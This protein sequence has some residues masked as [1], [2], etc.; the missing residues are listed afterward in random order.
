[1]SLRLL[2]LT[3]RAI[4]YIIVSAFIILKW[5]DYLADIGRIVIHSDVYVLVPYFLFSA[6]LFFSA[7]TVLPELRRLE[8]INRSNKM[9]RDKVNTKDQNEIS[10][11][12]HYNAFIRYGSVAFALYWIS[13]PFWTD[14]YGNW[15]HTA[16]YPFA[17]ITGSIIMVYALRT[18]WYAVSIGEGKIIVKGFCTREY[19]LENVFSVKLLRT[20]NVPNIEVTF[21]NGKRI[22]CGR[23]PSIKISVFSC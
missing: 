20:T 1:M 6:A 12:Y 8:A 19:L 17:I 18:I 13:A 14:G 10:V 5:R 7:R 11:K 15:S 22:G 23:F 16:S 3:L 2:F 4:I 9:V 21:S